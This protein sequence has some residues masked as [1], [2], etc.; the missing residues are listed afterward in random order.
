VIK[1]TPITRDFENGSEPSQLSHI[2][3]NV[4]DMKETKIVPCVK[5]QVSKVYEE[6][7]EEVM[8]S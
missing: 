3:C 5:C 1:G 8:M 6:G 7:L 2:S 4:R